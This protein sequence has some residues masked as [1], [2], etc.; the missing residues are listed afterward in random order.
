MYRQ[1]TVM[2]DRVPV[3]D[4]VMVSVAVIDCVPVV[5]SVALKVC[6]PLSAA[7]NVP[8]A[9]VMEAVLRAT[10]LARRTSAGESAYGP[11]QVTRREGRVRSNVEYAC[12]TPLIWRWVGKRRTSPS[13]RLAVRNWP[14]RPQ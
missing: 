9:M 7:T 2:P 12:E 1:L 10:R 11:S 3:I 4:G 5:F 13:P 14:C 6:V 8:M